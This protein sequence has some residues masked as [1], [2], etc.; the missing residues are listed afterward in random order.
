[1]NND[2]NYNQNQMDE[3]SDMNK[4]N[5]MSEDERN[6]AQTVSNR[7]EQMRGAGGSLGWLRNDEI[8]ELKA[9]WTTIQSKFVD[10]PRTSVEQADA[11]VAD[12]LVRIEK[13]FSDNRASLA[14]QKDISTEDL[15]VALQSYRSFLNRLLAI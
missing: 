5:V 1:M 14:G 15:R 2:P 3:Q 11:L 13:A 10:E 9:R 7:P 12:T 4:R 8:D 6:S